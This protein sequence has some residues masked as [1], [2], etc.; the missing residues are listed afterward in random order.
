[1]IILKFKVGDRVVYVN[2]G[3]EPFVTNIIDVI[4]ENKI[5]NAPPYRIELPSGK[6]AW[7][8]E[9]LLSLYED[10]KKYDRQYVNNDELYIISNGDKKLDPYTVEKIAKKID[11]IT[12]TKDSPEIQFF[13]IIAW[14]GGLNYGL[15]GGLEIDQEEKQDE[16]NK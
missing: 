15:N 12:S 6:K 8:S 5:H 16:S 3:H 1:M 10:N 2:D 4:D 7:V 14:I 9:S 11:Q 13:S